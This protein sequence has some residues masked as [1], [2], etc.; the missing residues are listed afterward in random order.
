MSYMD[1]VLEEVYWLS[2]RKV[3]VNGSQQQIAAIYK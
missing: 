1:T 3:I 2:K